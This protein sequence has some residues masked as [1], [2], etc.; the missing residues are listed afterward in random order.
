MIGKRRLVINLLS[1]AELDT[2]FTNIYNDY[3]ISYYKVYVKS[4]KK[5]KRKNEI[6]L[7]I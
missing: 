7:Y 6:I 4:K 2:N 3:I 1:Q 5:K